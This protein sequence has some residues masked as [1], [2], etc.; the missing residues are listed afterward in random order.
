MRVAA[1]QIRVTDD[2]GKNLSKILEYIDKAKSGNVDIVCFP[3]ACLNTSDELADIS[4]EI[5]AIGERCR[6]NSIW[7][8]FGS[9]FPVKGKVMNSVFLIDRDG[10]ICYRY[11]KVHPWVSEKKV[12]AGRSCR[13]IET[14]FGKIGIIDCWDFA[15][16]SFIQRLSRSGARIIFC[17][18]YLVDSVEDAE[19]M[20]AIPL[21]RAFENI[22]FYVSC[23]AFAP[24]SLSH[25]CIC[26][27]LR[28]LQRIDGKEGMIVA[29][30][31][32]DEIAPLKK[33]YDHL[34]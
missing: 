18:T 10:S 8:V 21:V 32:L 23:D 6:K 22:C 15:F 19:A 29:D 12:T 31:D 24:D 2:I 27:P 34:D 26:H 30:L 4:E 1:A 3:E 25:S 7:C 11:D 13:V 17:P 28:V 5:G 9:Y 14:E 33:H 16:P 20:K